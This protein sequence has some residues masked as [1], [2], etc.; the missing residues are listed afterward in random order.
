MYIQL[1]F[2]FFIF[3]TYTSKVLNEF[4]ITKKIIFYSTKTSEI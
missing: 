1:L 2:I 4:R 3:S